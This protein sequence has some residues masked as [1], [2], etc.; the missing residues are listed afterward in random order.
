[1]AKKRKY[2][3]VLKGHTTG[4]FDDWNDCKAQVEGF[5]GAVYKSFDSLEAAKQAQRVGFFPKTTAI[6]AQNKVS[7]RAAAPFI[8]NSISVDAACSGN[9]GLMEYRGV[10]NNTGEQIFHAGPFKNGTNNIGEFLALVHG[11]AYLQKQS[12]Q[13]PIYSDSRNAIA[14]LKQ[15]Q[16]KTTL[17]RTDE[18]REVWNL[19]ERALFWIKNNGYLNPILKWETEDWGENPADFGRK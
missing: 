8:K 1:M 13:I 14:W 18:T 9:P 2:Y 7:R 10:D 15:K 5:A 3:V 19:I 17:P 16:V 4:I 12:N 6:S 11:I